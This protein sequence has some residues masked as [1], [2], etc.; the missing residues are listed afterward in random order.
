MSEQKKNINCRIC[1][2]CDLNK[3][4]KTFSLFEK[5]NHSI[6][7]DKI[8]YIANIEIKPNDG[9]PST[10]C[11]DCLLQLETAII[12]KQKCEASNK[13]LQTVV[14]QPS[15]VCKVSIKLPFKKEV[16][17]DNANKRT[18]TTTSCP[19]I[20]EHKDNGQHLN[21]KQDQQVVLENNPKSNKAKVERLERKIE[22]PSQAKKESVIK[23]TKPLFVKVEIPNHL[24]IIPLTENYE[25]FNEIEQPDDDIVS[26]HEGP[27]HDRTGQTE[28]LTEDTLDK[29][30]EVDSKKINGEKK[31]KA[32]DLQLICDDCG[33]TFKTKCKLSVH[34]KKDH[35]HEKLI[36]SNCKR[37][38]KTFKA[39]NVH[40]KKMSRSCYAAT[41]VRIE[42]LG[43]D[44]VFH[45]K[46]CTYHTKNIKDIDAHLVTHNGIRRY[47]CKDCLKW[48]TQHSSLQGH[49]EA[50]H[51]DYKKVGTCQYCGKHIKGR[52][53]LYKHLVNHE[54]KSVQC[55]IC[56]KILKN[57][58]NL[59]NHMK[60]HSGVRS[61]TCTSCPA[62]FFTMAELC[63]HR[64]RV[65]CKA[66]TFKCNLCGYLTTTARLLK[67]H[68]SRHTATNVVCFMCGMFLDN[69]EKLAIHQKRHME[70]NFVCRHCDKGF[71]LRE[72]LRRHLAKIHDDLSPDSLEQS[73]PVNVKQESSV[74]NKLNS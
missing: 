47:Q 19:T 54:S 69:E 62:N 71:F 60:R 70:Q 9:L 4:H 46:D 27:I 24:C 40:R 63:N 29:T 59:R 25:S 45:C 67:T 56:K 50:H 33:E 22:K 53:K 73:K 16:H 68:I 1:L 49:R 44:R 66:K 3:E 7:S 10:V 74:E 14:Q 23:E 18:N 64:N 32:I 38:F 48:F 55:E 41:L 43:K 36:C 72:S 37:T 39:L 51:N 65:H 17:V 5:Y 61:Y 35:L 52:N 8:K 11:P 12:I 34:W 58:S 31:S 20:P 2:R 26:D 42:G 28:T 13:I 30:N 21:S 57:R 15:K 6:I